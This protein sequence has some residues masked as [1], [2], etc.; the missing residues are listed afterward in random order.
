V[1]WVAIRGSDISGDPVDRCRGGAASVTESGAI[2][3]VR[4]S[5]LT[6]YKGTPSLPL[7]LAAYAGSRRHRSHRGLEPAR[8]MPLPPRVCKLECPC[9]ARHRRQ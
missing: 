5:G 4:E 8:Q 2:S 3:G 6:V 1:Q 7:R 9:R